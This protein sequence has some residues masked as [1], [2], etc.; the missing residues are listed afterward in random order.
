MSFARSF[1]KIGSNGK[2]V[3]RVAKP[4]DNV[5]DLIQQKMVARNLDQIQDNVENAL[6]PIF[7]K[8][9]VNGILLTDIRLIVG[10]NKIDHGLGRDLRG[11]I[12]VGRNSAGT[13]YD[14]QAANKL[15]STLLVL[16]SDSF[17]TIN[18]WCF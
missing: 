3:S 1:R 13:V 17:M 8:E 10:T 12:I 6:A 7:S 5:E 16:Q 18:L 2:G 14:L 9:I 11:W 15:K 4:T